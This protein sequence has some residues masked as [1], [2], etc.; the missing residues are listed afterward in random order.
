MAEWTGGVK[1]ALTTGLDVDD[2]A[3]VVLNSTTALFAIASSTAADNVVKS[4]A[5]PGTGALTLSD[6]ESYYA[7]AGGVTNPVIERISDTKA[8]LCYISDDGGSGYRP[9]ARII[10]VSAEGVVSVGAATTL[11]GDT[12]SG[13]RRVF[14]AVLS[15]TAAV[16]ITY[17]DT[18][19]ANVLGLSLNTTSNTVTEAVSTTL[20]MYPDVS[21]P[22]FVF[23]F[24]STTA[25]LVG[26]EHGADTDLST[27]V[28]TY[29]GTLSVGAAQSLGTTY[30]QMAGGSWRRGA[31]VSS[32]RF[33][34]L[35]EQVAAPTEI[36]A[37]LW[38]I[39]AGTVG[40]AVD[41]LSV[42]SSTSIGGE[43]FLLGSNYGAAYNAGTADDLFKVLAVS[44]D[45]VSNTGEGVWS[46][47]T[48]DLT[49]RGCGA[50]DASTVL[51]SSIDAGVAYYTLLARGPSWSLTHSAGGIPGAIKV[52]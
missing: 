40:A 6:E 7:G 52:A 16:A 39:S 41:S 26:T 30:K 17:N 10:T 44:G 9:T 42:A 8:L 14:V 45:D 48:G 51:V 11:T 46:M 50:F 20:T 1:A 23:P 19:V 22:Y 38:P 49:R 24:N 28:I 21:R 33:L 32:T 25:I 27:W 34:T 5:S 29:S 31:A 4:G 12:A 13:S 15:E 35:L 3:A 43:L 37:V 36:F 18:L 47:D 2:L